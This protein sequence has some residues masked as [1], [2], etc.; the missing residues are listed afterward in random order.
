MLWEFRENVPSQG[1]GVRVL[2]MIYALCLNSRNPNVEKL[3]KYTSQDVEKILKQ[4]FEK[5]GG[6]CWNIR[7]HVAQPNVLYN[8]FI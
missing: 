1:C 8:L 4:G 3:K 6:S 7:D 5:I 2:P